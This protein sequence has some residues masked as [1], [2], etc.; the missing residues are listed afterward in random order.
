MSYIVTA[1]KWRPHL[2]GDVVSQKHV[3]G[4]LQ[5]AIRSGRIG[6]AY[7]FSGPRG[8]G[9]TTIARIFAKALNCEHGPA[10]EPCNT[11]SICQ[12]IQSGASMDIQE[13]DGASNNSVEDVRD[14]IATVGYHA[15]QC[16]YKI[17]II[18]EVHMLSQAAFNALLKTLE[19]PPPGV[20]FVFATTEP[21]KIPVTILSRCQRF[22]FHRLSIQEIAGKLRRIAEA[23]GLDIDDASTLLIARRAGG[24]MRDGESI[25]EQL[26]ASRGAS[27]TAADVAEVLGMADREVFFEIIDR[28]HARDTHGV[29]GLFT[30]YYDGGGDLK[31]F[32][33]GILGHLRDLLYA[34]YP[35]GLDQSPVSDEM[36]SR[37][38]TQAAWYESGDLLRM[39]TWVTETESSLAYAVMPVLRIEL[40]LAR[41]ASLETTIELRR[42]F[43]LLG[44]EQSASGLIERLAPRT[45]VPPVET[46]PVSIPVSDAEDVSVSA[47]EN[48]LY[49]PSEPQRNEE[50]AEAGPDINSIAKR[51]PEIVE[52]VGARKPALGPAL[53]VGTPDAYAG[54][55]LS[56]QFPADR[57]V[58]M[59]TCERF[60]GDIEKIIGTILGERVSIS[61]SIHR[62]GSERKKTN[63]IDDIISREPIVRDVLDRFG[64]EITDSWR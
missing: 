2:F 42:L 55:R 15:S 62:N 30:A 31:E 7:L 11:C 17:Y 24:A 26:K 60:R 33:E 19:E 63:E 64:G 59:E 32:L 47:Q 40:A 52:Q 21:Q 49:P 35:G 51:W 6:H 61:C 27:V 14:L 37:L 45:A 3:T 50:C 23:D 22:D 8:V 16:R 34:S 9:K 29:L 18:D 36:R 1:R 54:G 57:T 10:E 41:M 39:I 38:Q 28:C 43:E 48:V 13:L 5:N 4:T 53:A 44:G 56:V 20:I 12:S 46:H 58:Q 25:L